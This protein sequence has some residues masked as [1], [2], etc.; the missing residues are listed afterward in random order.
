MLV[1]KTREGVGGPLLTGTDPLGLLA[2]VPFPACRTFPT[3]LSPAPCWPSLCIRPWAL[4]CLMQLGD[5]YVP[6]SAPAEG[7]WFQECAA[8]FRLDLLP[9]L[10]TSCA[11]N[12]PLLLLTPRPS[13][14]PL[15]LLPP[16]QYVLDFLTS[17][18][19]NH[20]ASKHEISRM[21]TSPSVSKKSPDG[22]GSFRV[23]FKSTSYFFSFPF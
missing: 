10:P 18:S 2:A 20:L 14:L 21:L 23:F 13:R 4:R 5:K 16:Q 1:M 7:L 17:V 3:A 19:D 12:H 8:P 11:P 15:Q 6:H 9:P 22:I